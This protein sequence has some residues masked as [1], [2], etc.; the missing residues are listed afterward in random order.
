MSNLSVNDIKQAL[1]QFYDE[2]KAEV[3]PRF[4]K[5]GKGEYGEGDVFMGVAVPNVRKVAKEGKGAS[6]T[7]IEELLNSEIHECRACGL[8]ILTEQFK[9]SKSEEE[10]KD[11]YDFYLSHTERVNNWDLVDLSCYVI[12]GD[13]LMDKPRDILYKMLDDSFLWN[14]RIAIVSCWAFIRNH[15]FEDI[16]RLTEQLLAAEPKPH[17]L[18][19]KACGW[20]LREVGKRGGLEQ[21]EAFLEEHAATMP[22]TMLRYAIEK[23]SAE[24]RRYYMNKKIKPNIIT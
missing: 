6:M 13:Y 11:I 23:M 3:L 1:M 5:T 17:D 16:F 15:D 19:Q 21:L 10:R 24:E 9:K 7:L 20:M 14:K 12:V 2:E 4:F 18:M 22:R 8:F